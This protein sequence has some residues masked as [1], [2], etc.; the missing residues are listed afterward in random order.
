MNI[1]LSSSRLPAVT[2]LEYCHY[3]VKPKTINQVDWIILNF[4]IFLDILQL[5]TLSFTLAPLP[6]P[7]KKE[8]LTWKIGSIYCAVTTHTKDKTKP[9]CCHFDNSFC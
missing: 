9:I 6:H 7:I 2:W 5:H 1:L 3:G 8:D 4:G